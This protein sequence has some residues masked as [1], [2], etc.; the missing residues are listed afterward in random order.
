LAKA[1]LLEP[2]IAKKKTVK[3]TKTMDGPCARLNR[4]RRSRDFSM[5]GIVTDLLV[6]KIL[7][8]AEIGIGTRH[9]PLR[10]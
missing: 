9:A 2:A 5:F 8:L 10:F 6:S 1:A 3:I 4:A 7:R